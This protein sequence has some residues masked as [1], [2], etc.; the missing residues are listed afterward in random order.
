MERFL[1]PDQ[2]QRMKSMLFCLAFMTVSFIVHEV[3]GKTA[4]LLGLAICSASFAIFLLWR[5][6][7]AVR[8]P[9]P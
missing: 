7:V 6:G 4:W 2:F 5:L 1:D 3:F 9:R 8:R